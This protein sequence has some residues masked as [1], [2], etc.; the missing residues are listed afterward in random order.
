M[1]FSDDKMFASCDFTWILW[2]EIEQIICSHLR[3]LVW[4]ICV[5]GREKI[6]IKLLLLEIIGIVLYLFASIC[7]GT[8]EYLFQCSCSN[9]LVS[10]LCNWPAYLFKDIHSCISGT[11]SVYFG[12]VLGNLY[13]EFSQALTRYTHNLLARNIL[14]ES[15]Q[16]TLLNHLCVSPWSQDTSN[17]WPLQVY[18][19]TLAVLAQ[20][21]P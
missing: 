15:L 4:N 8:I 19:R 21:I 2:K 18:P 5:I 16:G 10:L 6:N 13:S 12:A 1:L 3:V 9:G 20:V 14:T 17:T 11:I 7:Y